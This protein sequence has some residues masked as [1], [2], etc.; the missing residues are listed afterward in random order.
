MYPT[1]CSQ[2]RAAPVRLGVEFS[3]VEERGIQSVRD[4]E[5]SFEDQ[6]EILF[7]LE[8]RGGIWKFREK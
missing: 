3:C 4:A 6:L 7:I 8:W 5:K 2:G 1:H